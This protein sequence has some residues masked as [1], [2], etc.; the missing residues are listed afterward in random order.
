MTTKKRKK[1]QVIAATIMTVPL[2]Y[3]GVLWLVG[4]AIANGRYLPETMFIGLMGPIIGGLMLYM[5]AD[6][7]CAIWDDVTD[8]VEERLGD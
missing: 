2:V 6:I 8:W 4:R 5:I 7:A 1:A 3:A